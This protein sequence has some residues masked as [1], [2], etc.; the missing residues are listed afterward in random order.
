M[1]KSIT[2]PYKTVLSK[3]IV[4]ATRMVSTK[5]TYHK[6]RSFATISFI[7]LK[8]EF[9]YLLFVRAS[10]L[11]EGVLSLGVSLSLLVVQYFLYQNC[12]CQMPS[13]IKTWF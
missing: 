12:W 6:E 5:W 10:D 7:F 9:T 11:F 2:F 3:A 1:I 4:K 8:T 13:Q